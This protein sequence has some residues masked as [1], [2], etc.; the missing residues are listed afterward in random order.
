MYKGS[1]IKTFALMALCLVGAITACFGQQ[2]P[3]TPPPAIENPPAGGNVS[4]FSRIPYEF[5]LT[6]LIV[7]FG[8]LVILLLV[9]HLRIASP[10]PE[11]IT[12]PVIVVTVV[13]GALILVTAGY[14]NEQ[15]APAFGLFGTIVGYI[16]GRMSQAPIR[17]GRDTGAPP[18]PNT[19]SRQARGGRR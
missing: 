2:A 15:I 14:S 8:L 13:V 18:P 17:G 5:W 12:R 7:T 10:K 9:R 19:E 4:P 1:I 6:V 11:D 16:L 3:K